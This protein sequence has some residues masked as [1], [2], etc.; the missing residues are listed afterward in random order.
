VRTIYGDE[1]SHIRP[2]EHLR[3]FLAVTS[4]ARRIARSPAEGTQPAR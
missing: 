4:R 1:T 2:A 3:E